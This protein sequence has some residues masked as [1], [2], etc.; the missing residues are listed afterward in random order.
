MEAKGCFAKRT[1]FCQE[2]Y[3][4]A[5]DTQHLARSE[6]VHPSKNNLEG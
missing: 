4:C 3:Q 5:K 2:I 1:M 6:S